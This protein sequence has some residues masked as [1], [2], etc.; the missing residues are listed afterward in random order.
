MRHAGSL[1]S[2][3]GSVE[4]PAVKV[5]S[6]SQWT[7]REFL[8]INSKGEQF[9]FLVG[10][11]PMLRGFGMEK[12]ILDC[13][14]LVRARAASAA[15][16]VNSSSW[17]SPV[18]ELLAAQGNISTQTRDGS[19]LHLSSKL[20]TEL[21]LKARELIKDQ[22]S[23]PK[24]SPTGTQ[25]YIM[26]DVPVTFSQVECNGDTPPENGQQKITKIIEEASD[27]DGTP[28]YCRVEPRLNV[29]TERNQEKSEKLQ[30]DILLSSSMDEKILKEKPEEKLYVVHKAITDLSLQETSVD[31]MAL[32]QGH[33]WEKIPLSSSNQEISRQKESIS[34]QPLE[35]REDEELEN[36]ALQ[37]TE[38]EWLGFQKP[39]QV[40]ASHSKQDEEQE[41]WD[42]EINNDDDDDCKDDEDEVRVIEFKKKNEEDTQLKEEGDASEDS[43]LSSPSSQPVTPDE[44]PT[45]GKKGDFSRN[46]Y[47]RYN[48][49]S[50]RKIRKGNTKQRIDEFESMIN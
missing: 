3:Q 32:R 20:S 42:E 15:L 2:N 19:E 50:Y 8:M 38:I 22:G 25:L 33:Q 17:W 39:S 23:S 30:E 11:Y 31:E 9:H 26:T 4:P 14:K 16:A 45:F 21:D 10:E 34:E 49:I 46:A 44:Q 5:W 43:P 48:T 29:P 47:S 13:S 24:L 37:A 6:Y 28:P 12:V 1:F 27:V 41:V 40:D 35:E 18:V 36:T 7:T